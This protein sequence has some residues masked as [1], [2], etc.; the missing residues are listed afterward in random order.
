MVAV[1]IVEQRQGFAAICRAIKLNIHGIND[2]TVL[3]VSL[4]AVEV[5]G[6]LPDAVIF[7]DTRPGSTGVIGT[8]KPAVL[9]F[10]VGIHAIRVSAR[11]GDVDLADQH[12]GHTGRTRDVG[13]VVA[14]VT[15][16]EQ[17][18]AFASAGERPRRAKHLPERRVQYVGI[19]G[20]KAQVYGGGAVAAE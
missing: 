17:P 3:R 10:H 1:R 19:F 15:G 11:N 12:L 2:I 16:L 13:P 7:A 14:A 9:S 4:D 18:A 5:K 8:K 6:A 20:I